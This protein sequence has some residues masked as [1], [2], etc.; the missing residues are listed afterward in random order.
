M[1]TMST[2]G[3]I[4]SN[5]YVEAIDSLLCLDIPSTF[6][7]RLFMHTMSINGLIHHLTFMLR[8]STHAY[9]TDIWAN[10]LIIYVTLIM[11]IHHA[12]RWPDTPSNIYVEAI[13]SCTLCLSMA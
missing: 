4:Y 7:L 13:D 10:T 12:Q 3:L 9:D 5:I 1:H 11:Y 6:M 8:L 2:N